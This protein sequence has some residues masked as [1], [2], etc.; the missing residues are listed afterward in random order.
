MPVF[1]PSAPML[2][3][4]SDFLNSCAARVIAPGARLRTS[5]LA[6]L[7][8]LAGDDAQAAFW[9]GMAD[10]QVGF[11]RADVERWILRAREAAHPP[12]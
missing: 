2:A 9:A 3:S 6:R 12:A 8:Q 10:V 4:D 1:S 5:D 11:N 7:M